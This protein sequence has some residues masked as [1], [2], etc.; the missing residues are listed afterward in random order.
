MKVQ[1]ITATGKTGTATVSD[2]L[3]SG[4]PNMTLIAQAVRVYRANLRQGTSR[5]QTRSQV[6]R[7]KKK[8]F[9]Q[10]GT[11]NARHGA[12]SA[13]LFVGGGVAHGPKADRN[14]SLSMS[15]RMKRKALAESLKAQAQTIYVTGALKKVSGKTA[16]LA[17]LLAEIT[18]HNN[19]VLIIAG[20]RNELLERAAQNIP[21]IL[22]MSAEYVTAL[23]V[24]TADVVVLT[25]DA[26]AKL[27]ER[28]AGV[29]P[30]KTT[31]TA[32]KK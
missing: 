16:E 8:W 6:T 13:P 27:I 9:K 31:K 14:W 10:K 11:G 3:F 2:Q 32:K 24:A 17:K 25:D 15:T 12:R 20:E 21:Q 26:E 7:T 22:V 5:V 1:S 18:T 30:E 29:L 23:E 4:E 28:L 19:T